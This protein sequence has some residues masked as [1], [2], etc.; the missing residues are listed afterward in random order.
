MNTNMIH[1]YYPY[2]IIFKLLKIPCLSSIYD[3][4]P[5]DI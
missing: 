5:H 2:D 4:A 3:V 1:Y